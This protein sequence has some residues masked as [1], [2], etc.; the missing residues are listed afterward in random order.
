MEVQLEL[1]LQVGSSVMHLH[2]SLILALIALET[3]PQ[4]IP[5][6][7]NSRLEREEDEKGKDFIDINSTKYL[8]PR[9]TII[10][11]QNAERYFSISYKKVRTQNNNNTVQNYCY[12]LL[13][14]Q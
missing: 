14:N 8:V 10:F 3:E 6:T 7:I 13:H 5:P 12:A 4:K 9:I 1:P 11:H 2:K